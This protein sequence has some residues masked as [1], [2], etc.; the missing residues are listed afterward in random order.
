[1]AKWA[2]PGDVVPKQCGKLRIGASFSVGVNQFGQADGL[3]RTP[4]GSEIT[5]DQHDPGEVHGI[6]SIQQESHDELPLRASHMS[7][8]I[9]KDPVLTQVRHYVLSGWPVEQTNELRPYFRIRHELSTSHGCVLW[10]FRTIIPTRFRRQLLD[11]LHATHAGMGRMKA[12]ARRDFW[13]PS[14]DQDIEDLARQCPTCTLNSKQVAKSPLKQWNVPLA[15]WQRIHIDFV[16]KF[17]NLYF[18]VVVDA[19]SKWLEV[20]I[21]SN[22][23][24]STTIATLKSLFARY[25]LCEEIVSDNG[26]QF[27]SD[28]FSQFCA[29]NG[30]RHIRTAPGRPQSNGQAE[31]YVDTVKSAL[32]KRLQKEGRVA[33]VLYKFLFVYRSTVHPT[34]NASPAEIFLKREL[35]TVLDLLRPNAAEASQTA[36]ERYQVNFDRRTKQEFYHSGDKVIVR[37]FKHD[38]KEVKW[39]AGVLIDRYGSRR[40]SVQVDHQTWRRHENQMKHRH[41]TNDQ[42]LP[43][44]EATTPVHTSN[45][46]SDHDGDQE[47]ASSAVIAPEPEQHARPE[48]LRRSS[49]HRKPVHRP[50]ED[51]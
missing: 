12:E 25:G 13:W 40:W 48:L 39:T 24:T 14:L 22:T 17:E 44:V 4:V 50:I 38:P 41:W 43:R 19:H 31:R 20:L 23:S 1:M 32:I 7:E 47:E 36:R 27:T 49:R 18:L 8:A 5:S 51:I 15:P 35:R 10:N 9:G 45:G 6:A 37:D 26:P 3:S 30:I 29:R 21:M 2:A 28:E 11:H 16:G 33:D 46:N 42:E 34:T